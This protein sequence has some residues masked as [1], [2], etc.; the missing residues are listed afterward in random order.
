[1][2]QVHFTQNLSANA[3]SSPLLYSVSVTL[4]VLPA[5]LFAFLSG[6]SL[7]LSIAKQRAQ[8][9]T[10]EEITRGGLRRAMFLFGTGIA[11]ACLVWLP[12]D[13][14]DW[15]I[16]T[17]LGAST[18][19]LIL[20]RR[21]P[22]AALLGACIV[23]GFASPFLRQLSDY[24]SHWQ[25]NEYF[26]DLTLR[27][28]SLGFLLNGYFPLLPWIVFPAVGYVVGAA[29][30]RRREDESCPVE[31]ALLGI[32]LLAI[33]G[34]AAVLSGRAPPWLPEPYSRSADLADVTP[35]W[36]EHYATGLTMYPASTPYVL[37]T[38]GFSLLSLALLHR[39]IDQ[40]GG[41]SKDSALAT[42]F[43]RYSYFALTAY[44]VHHAVHLW[45][46]WAYA[47]WKGK[48]DPEYFE[49]S[50]MD[51]P[52][53]LLLALAFIV[54]FYFVAIALEHRRRYSFEGFMRWIC[55]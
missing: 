37:A 15:D 46:L 11:F 50:A 29:L 54:A 22:A 39:W 6:V 38:L 20:L 25:K 48:T 32:G 34:I 35:W 41:L 23:A 33:A 14:F 30:Q 36:R 53:A 26:S 4:G 47:I 19:L 43:R 51:T 49:G 9:R 5:P 31:M 8:G 12:R 27:Q 10:E 2:I 21:V 13:V 3:S 42:F 45:P 52:L 40:A 28:V 18:A 7:P 44:L 16:L 24:S 17:L 1:M 55:E